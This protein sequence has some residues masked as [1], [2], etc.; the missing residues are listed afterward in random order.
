M[1]VYYPLLKH[2]HMLLA[3]ISLLLFLYR[4]RLALSGRLAQ[5]G[6]L[7]KIVPHINDT[8]LLGAGLALAIMLQLSPGSQPWLLAKLIA[9]V[10]YIGCGMVALKSKQSTTRML[11]G[12]LA[13]VLF[14]YMAGA[15]VSK[16]P[17]AWFA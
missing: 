1:I 15:A 13:L 2:L 9:L 4:W 5:A 17:L 6:K 8:L 11:A 16:S 10:G 3:V 7:L 12:V 14:A